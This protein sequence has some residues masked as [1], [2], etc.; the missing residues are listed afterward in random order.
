MDNDQGEGKTLA[1]TEEAKYQFLLRIV[2][3]F[4]E[5][6]KTINWQRVTMPG[7][8]TKSLQNMWTKINKA[9]AELEENDANGTPAPTPTK[10]AKKTATPRKTGG[11]KKTVTP[12]AADDDEE[13]CMPAED[14]KRTPK[15]RATSSTPRK[16]KKAKKDQEDI[17]QEEN[18]AWL[19]LPSMTP[20]AED[21]DA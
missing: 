11:K 20:K 6:G 17:G 9:V 14:V 3:Q 10:S 19:A 12:E 2:A 7:R 16:S 4:K 21:E 13:T 5:D 8:T 15:K 18:A 1:W